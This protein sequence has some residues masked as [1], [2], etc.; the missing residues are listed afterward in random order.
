MRADRPGLGPPR[1]CLAAL[2]FLSLLSSL[3]PIPKHPHEEGC[4][5]VGPAF[6]FAFAFALALRAERLTA[7]EPTFC[8][9]P[10]DIARTARS[11][12]RTNTLR[13]LPP[14]RRS[15]S[16]HGPGTCGPR[17]RSKCSSCA[18]GTSIITRTYADDRSTCTRLAY[19]SGDWTDG[20]GMS[21]SPTHVPPH[22]S[23][24]SFG[25]PGPLSVLIQVCT[26][27]LCAQRIPPRH[28]HGSTSSTIGTRSPHIRHSASSP[29]T[30]PPRAWGR[31]R[32]PGATRVR[33]PVLTICSWRLVT[34]FRGHQ[35]LFVDGS[36]R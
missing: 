26:Q 35:F 20:S 8:L 12:H 25:R 11:F 33:A 31:R 17:C 1:R 9:P 23:H 24:A 36:P 19:S 32:R 22:T 14:S 3:A 30:A 34:S 21:Y 15:H 7:T 10:S 16:S 2:S 29:M 18:R 13:D 28:R 4:R 6:A 27:D 5:R